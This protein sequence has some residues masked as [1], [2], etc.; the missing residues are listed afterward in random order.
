MLCCVV[1]CCVVLCCVVLCCV[2]LCCVVLCCVVLCC[3]GDKDHI[4]ALLINQMMLLF[5][6]SSTMFARKSF[7]FSITAISLSYNMRSAFQN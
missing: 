7:K 4:Y 3:T 1:L 5:H 6:F 2:V